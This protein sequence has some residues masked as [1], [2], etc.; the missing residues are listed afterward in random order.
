MPQPHTIKQ[1]DHAWPSSCLKISALFT[2]R[3]PS[4]IF[5]SRLVPVLS[6][7]FCFETCNAK[8][9]EPLNDSSSLQYGRVDD[10]TFTQKLLSHVRFSPSVS[11]HWSGVEVGMEEWKRDAS[12]IH[13]REPVSTWHQKSEGFPRRR[14]SL[15][16]GNRL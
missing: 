3:A 2:F 4:R 8:P 9:T 5:S 15:C 1:V 16:Q 14:G 6:M 12:E 11:C 13:N 7:N 10:H